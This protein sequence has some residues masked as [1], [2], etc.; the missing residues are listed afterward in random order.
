MPWGSLMFYPDRAGPD[1]ALSNQTACS[2]KGKSFP[3]IWNSEELKTTR[4]SILDGESEKMGCQ[5]CEY[6]GSGTGWYEDILLM[7]KSCH[8]ER[9]LYLNR[10]EFLGR[11]IVLDSMPVTLS[12]DLWYKCNFRCIMCDLIHEEMEMETGLYEDL[13]NEYT[14]TAVHLHVSG[15]EPLLHKGFRGYLSTPK[16]MPSALSITTNGSLLDKDILDKLKKFNDVNMHIS[17]DSFNR[18]VFSRMRPGSD[19]SVIMENLNQALEIKSGL[20]QNNSGKSWYISIQ[21]LACILNVREFP[22][23]IRHAGKMGIDAIH[24]CEIAGEFPE[25]DFSV[26]RGLISDTDLGNLGAEIKS[27]M[28]HCREIE[29]SGMDKLLSTFKHSVVQEGLSE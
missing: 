8:A 17:I 16:T 3:E 7:N 11:Q 6:Y 20:R 18:D 22:S 26:N 4:Q 10:D 25:Y 24:L 23:Y 2:I 1:C 29:Y 12:A 13:F 9:N 28:S 5:E 14:K 27:A 19:F 21:F 15:G